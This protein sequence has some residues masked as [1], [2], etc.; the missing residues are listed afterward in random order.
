R[1]ASWSGCS[2]CGTSSACGRP[3]A[4]R[5]RSP[6]LSGTNNAL[7]QANVD[8]VRKATEAFIALDLE[9]WASFIDA[10]CTVY[11]R[12]EEPGVEESY[13]G[14]GGVGTYLANWYAGWEEYTAEPLE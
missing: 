3:R 10:G 9:R 4:R 1:T 12:A 14:M 7:T 11:P 8:I 6:R 5:F 2:R 13:E